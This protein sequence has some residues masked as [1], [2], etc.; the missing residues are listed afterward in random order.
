MCL[1]SNSKDSFEEKFFRWSC[2]VLIYLRIIH[3]ILETYTSMINVHLLLTIPILKCVWKEIRFTGILEIS[4]VFQWQW[5]QVMSHGVQKKK[6]WC[7]WRKIVSSI[8]TTP[9]SFLDSSTRGNFLLCEQILCLIIFSVFI[10]L[11]AV[12]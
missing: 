10:Y 12:L 1:N 11:H 2:R 8:K 4:G 6:W 3:K 7:M 9:R 5:C